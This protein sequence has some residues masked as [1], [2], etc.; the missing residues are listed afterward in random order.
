MK[1]IYSFEGKRNKSS[2]HT[3]FT[4]LKTRGE[5][6]LSQESGTRKLTTKEI[7]GLLCKKSD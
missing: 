3:G 2:F 1:K 6:F 7:R 4:V 5:Y